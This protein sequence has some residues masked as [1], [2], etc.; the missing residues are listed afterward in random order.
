M[1]IKQTPVPII[2][3]LERVFPRRQLAIFIQDP[4]V[5][6][7][8]IAAGLLFDSAIKYP[9]IWALAILFF[10]IN[11]YTHEKYV[12][13]FGVFPQENRGQNAHVMAHILSLETRALVYKRITNNF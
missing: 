3:S 7:P 9:A 8:H 5:L 2:H 1:G 13:S 12:G 4:V 6:R 10:S 11:T